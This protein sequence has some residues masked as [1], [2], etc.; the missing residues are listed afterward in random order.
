MNCVFD[1]IPFAPVSFE[2]F[3]A[4]VAIDGIRQQQGKRAD[5][6]QRP[7]WS[8]MRVKKALKPTVDLP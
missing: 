7:N 8:C 3:S 6:V 4:Y 2:M 1:L 5:A